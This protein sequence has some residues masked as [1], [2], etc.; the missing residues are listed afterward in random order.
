MPLPGG[1][2]LHLALNEPY[3]AAVVKAIIQAHGGSVEAASEPGAGSSF[4]VTLP[5]TPAANG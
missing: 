1:D 5:I 3:Y 2:G 4:T